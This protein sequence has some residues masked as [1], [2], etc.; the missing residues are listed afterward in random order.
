MKQ[1]HSISHTI[2][3]MRKFVVLRETFFSFVFTIFLITTLL[4]AP[5]LSRLIDTVPY[6]DD[7][8]VASA[9]PLF[10]SEISEG[11]DLISKD[12]Y[13]E[14][15][16]IFNRIQQFHPEHPA[17][18]FLKA[19]AYQSWMSHYRIAKFQKH[20]EENVQLTIDKGKALLTKKADDPWVHFYLGAAFG[21]RAFNRFGKHDWIGAYFDAK[22]GISHLERALNLDPRLYDVYLGLGTYHYWRTAKSGFI[23]IIAFWISDKRELGLRQLDFARKHSLYAKNE[24]RYNL[25]AAYFDHGQHEKALKLLN[26]VNEKQANWGLS[27][28]YYKG[29]IMVKLGKWHEAESI[30]RHLLQRLE[31]SKLAS[32]GYRVE[33]KYWIAMSLNEQSRISEALQYTEEA[34]EQSGTR[35]GH[36]EL[37]GPFE[38]FW[39]IKTKLNELKKTLL[40][41]SGVLAVPRDEGGP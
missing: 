30:F 26:P 37:E 3:T 19:A 40:I 32:I 35:N 22:N 25:I 18:T 11:V 31:Q 13:E 39:E 27:D 4:N 9:S 23:R 8:G 1:D 33:S 38:S 16:K 6:I 28:L 10:H 29:R 41:K 14:S 20:V 34:I 17:P 12:K 15:L 5:A 2:H 36:L 21:Y 7:N 24:A